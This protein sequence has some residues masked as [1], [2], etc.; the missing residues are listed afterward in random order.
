VL[1]SSALVGE[2][3]GS[4][5]AKR[6]GGGQAREFGPLRE[7]DQSIFAEELAVRVAGLDDAVGV[8][9]QPIA[10]LE[11][12]VPDGGPVRPCSLHPERCARRMREFLDRPPSAHE[13]GWRVPGKQVLQYSG[14]GVEAGEHGGDELRPPGFRSK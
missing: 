5:P 11:L 3:G 14:G 13:Q 2:N 1:Q 8:E 12:F 9:Q 4:E 10:G 6:L 7:I